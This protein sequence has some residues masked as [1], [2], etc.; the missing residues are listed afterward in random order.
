[1]GCTIPPRGPQYV[2]PTVSVD[3]AA[4]IV[5][6]RQETALVVGSASSSEPWVV[7]ATLEVDRRDSLLRMVL[8][9]QLGIVPGT[10]GRRRSQ[11]L[12][13]PT[14]HPSAL[15]EHVPFLLHGLAQVP[16]EPAAAWTLYACGQ[17]GTRVCAVH[18]TADCL[19]LPVRVHS[20]NE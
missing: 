2:P 9:R 20:P 11:D 15:G 16:A 18:A 5:W 6:A 8:Q 14:G 1:L 17:C 12:L 3:V 10:R 4:E 7:V 13:R 19:A